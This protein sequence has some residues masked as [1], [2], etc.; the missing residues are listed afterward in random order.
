[1]NSRND[2]VV[3][4]CKVKDSAQFMS[5]KTCKWFIENI[6]NQSFS[7]F[8]HHRQDKIQWQLGSSE[9]VTDLTEHWQL[10]KNWL[11]LIICRVVYVWESGL[12]PGKNFGT[13]MC[14]RDPIS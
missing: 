6:S 10:F 2:N 14:L 3:G 8:L 1:M 7:V 11:S 13:I 4:E 9:K 12:R 5:E